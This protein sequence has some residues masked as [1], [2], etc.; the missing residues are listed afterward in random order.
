M[1]RLLLHL[2]KLLN[3]RFVYLEVLGT[4][5]PFVAELLTLHATKGEQASHMERGVHQDAC[6]ATKLLGIEGS[7]AGGHDEVGCLAFHS[8]PQ[9]AHSLE[10]AHRDVGTE[11][12]DTHGIKMIAHLGGCTTAASRG[13]SM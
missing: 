5:L 11:H 1:E 13:K 7:H 2:L 4:I 12:G 9:E 3:E 6:R 8:L 10:G